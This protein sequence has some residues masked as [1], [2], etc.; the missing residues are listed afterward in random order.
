MLKESNLSFTTFEQIYFGWIIGFC[1][2][3]G[4]VIWSTNEANF[5]K[6]RVALAQ[7]DAP[8]NPYLKDQAN[9]KRVASEENN[10]EETTLS[11]IDYRNV[12][13][14]ITNQSKQ[15]PLF[16]TEYLKTVAPEVSSSLVSSILCIFFSFDSTKNQII[17]ISLHGFF[18]S[19][20][21]GLN[22]LTWT[23]LY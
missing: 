9:F 17:L 1:L 7:A 5:T 21:S 8:S 13:R 16:T 14:V 6:K 20:I 22:Q 19:Q 18:L 2:V 4:V 15:F 11:Q 23:V 12:T 10:I 3:V